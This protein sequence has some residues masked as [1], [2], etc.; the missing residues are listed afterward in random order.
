MTE[1]PP[2]AEG[3][4]PNQGPF[5]ERVIAMNF[6]ADAGKLMLESSTSVSEVLDRLRRFLPSVGLAGCSLDATMSS[7]ILSFWLPGQALPITVMREISVGSPRLERLAGA[8]ELL[9]GVEA[10]AIELGRAVDQLRTLASVQP[11]SHW[12]KRIASMVSVVGWVV[13]VDGIDLVTILVAMVATA[14]TFPIDGLVRRLRLPTIGVMF[15]LATIVAAIPNLLAAAGVSLLVGPAVVGALFPHLPGRAFVSSVIDGLSNAPLSSLSRGIQALATA[16]FLALGM[17]VGNRIGTG[18]GLSYEPDATSTP[19]VPSL[20]GAAVG[21]V[22]LAVAW[23]MPRRQLAPA[24]AISVVGWLIVSLFGEEIGGRADWPAYAIAAGVVGI[25]S[26]VASELQGSSSS[27]Y[28]GVAILPL[29]PGFILYTGMLA[30]AQGDNSAAG[31]ALG[32]AGIISLAI[33]IG[34]ALGLGFGRDTFAGARH[35]VTAR[36]TGDVT[37]S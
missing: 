1:T 17:L 34:V 2:G 28:S 36:Q 11:P 30:I 5:G 25:A 22:G 31:A 3:W 32:D 33:A 18:F 7:L 10:G 9:D 27:L 23:S 15:F 12:V 35:V 20:I 13:F 6:V 21:I 8:D 26:A 24:A 14:F 19:L 37:Q 4:D 16:G 29:A